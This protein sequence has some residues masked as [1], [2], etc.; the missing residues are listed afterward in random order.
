MLGRIISGKFGEIIARQKTG[1]EVELGELLVSY[2]ELTKT[3]VIYQVTDLFYGSQISQQNLE[4]VAGLSLEEDASTHIFDGNLRNYSLMKLKPVITLKDNKILIGKTLTPFF[5]ELYELNNNDLSFLEFPKNKLLLGHLRNGSVE[6]HAPVYL[7]GRDVFSHHVLICATTGKG[8]SVLVKNILWNSI[9]D[10]YC[11]HLIFDPH[12]EYYGRNELGLK[13]NP[14]KKV[15]YYSTNPLPGT[16]TLT[17]NINNLKPK[18]FSGVVNFSDAQL[19]ALSCYYK[20]FKDYWIEA[21]IMQKP[22]SNYKFDESTISVVSRRLASLLDIKNKNDALKCNGIFQNQTGETTVSEIIKSLNDSKTIII[23]TSHFSGS[24]ELLLASVIT[25][26]IYEN[27]KHKKQTGELKNT[28]IISIVLEEA[29]RVIG[30]EVFAQGS[31]IF[32]TI[33]REGR[34]FGIGLIAITQLPSLIPREI[35]A[36]MNTK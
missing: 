5:S 26:K 29:P 24:E 25:T 12:D 4:L 33:A 23:D 30:K 15:V 28:P 14:S 13:D 8:K 16:N 10:E 36:N 35:L 31:N 1:T 34:K 3:K 2:D 17:I 27:N 19:Q 11:A 32:G 7:N 18:H 21:A 9:E 6:L 22:F 20:E